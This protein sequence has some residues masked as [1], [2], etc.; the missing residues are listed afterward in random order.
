MREHHAVEHEGLVA[1]G[2]GAAVESGDGVQCPGNAADGGARDRAPEQGRPDL[3]D[4]A[5]RRAEHEAGKDDP[6]DLAGAARAVPK[7]G[8]SGGFALVLTMHEMS[9][10]LGGE[11]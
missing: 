5:G 6:V 2:G 3:A 4:P 10:R 7:H 9:V 1:V 8:G 11:A